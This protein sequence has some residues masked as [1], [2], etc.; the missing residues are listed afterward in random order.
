MSKLISA[1]VV[2]EALSNNLKVGDMVATD[3]MDDAIFATHPL[4]PRSSITD[5]VLVNQELL[6]QGRD[7]IKVAQKLSTQ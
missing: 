6:D 4:L 1:Q 5:S 7:A 2:I 3:R